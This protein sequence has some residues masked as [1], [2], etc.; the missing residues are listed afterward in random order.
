MSGLLKKF[1]LKGARVQASANDI[2]V[3]VE[4]KTREEAEEKA[5]K[6]VKIMNDWAQSRCITLHNNQS[7]A[8]IIRRQYETRPPI[9]KVGN[10]K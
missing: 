8:M 10:K 7:E 9:V 5:S 4:F 2:V 1:S 6:A 3:V